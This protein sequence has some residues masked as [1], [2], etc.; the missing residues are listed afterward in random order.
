M[1]YRPEAAEC[2][3][4]ARDEC[5]EPGNNCYIVDNK[6]YKSAVIWEKIACPILRMLF[7]ALFPHSHLDMLAFSK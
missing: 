1:D 3:E 7:D 5:M 2:A 6:R 4:R